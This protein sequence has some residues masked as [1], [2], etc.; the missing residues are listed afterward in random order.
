MIKEAAKHAIPTTTQTTD[1]RHKLPP[2]IIKLIKEKRKLRKRF[3]KEKSRSAK[4][5]LKSQV[6]QKYRRIKLEISNY[7]EEGYQLLWKKVEEKGAYDFYKV[8]KLFLKP[9]T[10]RG[11]QTLKHND[12]IAVTDDEKAHTMRE[13]YEQIYAKPNEDPEYE[14]LERQAR[15]NWTYMKTKCGKLTEDKIE[16]FDTKVTIED[17]K[18]ALKKAKNTAPGEDGI[19][20]R[21]IRQLP[22]NILAT[23]AELYET[24]IEMAYFPKLWKEG[25][26]TLIPKPGKTLS[27]PKNYRP[28]T[29]LPALGKVFERISVKRISQVAEGRNLIPN[30]QAGFRRNRSTQ[31][32]LLKIIQAGGATI[33]NGR[34]AMVSTMFDIEKAYDKLW[35]EGFALKLKQLGFSDKLIAVIANYLDDRSIVIQVNSSMS[36][37][38]TKIRNPTRSNNFSITI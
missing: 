21:Y 28:I 4:I 11:V 25:M 35:H 22:D 12:K 1:R 29:L 19:Y 30:T 17:I 33:Q 14:D 10:S 24:S 9:A 18:E 32:Q 13:L 20:Y 7:K 31:D 5:V 15:N 6:N 16:E 23:L 38:V 3:Q 37:P 36:D 27:D 2:H 34:K 26:V 8:V